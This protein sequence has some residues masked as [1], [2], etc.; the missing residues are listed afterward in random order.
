MALSQNGSAKTNQKPRNITLSQLQKTKFRKPI[1]M[2]LT[3]RAVGAS[4]VTTNHI[5]AYLG[6]ALREII[7]S[8]AIGPTL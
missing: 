7:K 4:F 2:Q 1:I 8:N 6:A 5:G 3:S